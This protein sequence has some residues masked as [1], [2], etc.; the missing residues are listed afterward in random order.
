MLKTQNSINKC[1]IKGN[2]KVHIQ[3]KHNTV[4]KLCLNDNNENVLK[5]IKFIKVICREL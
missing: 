2:Y 3:Y 5:N 4:F 1:S